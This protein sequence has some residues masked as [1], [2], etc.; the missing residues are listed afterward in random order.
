MN[1]NTI[2]SQSVGSMPNSY[3]APEVMTVSEVVLNA[4]TVRRF[5]RVHYAKITNYDLSDFISLFNA[6]SVVDLSDWG[7]SAF[8]SLTD[9]QK[10]LLRMY[11]SYSI[12]EMIFLH[13]E[14]AKGLSERMNSLKKKIRSQLVPLSTGTY[15]YELE[16]LSN[17]YS[18]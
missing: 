10:A 9:A 3:Y 15:E 11:Y 12:G 1:G 5:L 7:L 17:S 6:Q 2:A 4:D 8:A 16:R 18:G 14:D 13:D